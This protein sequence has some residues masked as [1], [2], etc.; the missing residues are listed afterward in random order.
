MI[1]TFKI[2]T[3]KVNTKPE[4]FFQT[5]NESGKLELFRGKKIFKK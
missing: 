1:E 5:R 2:L 4:N 3:E